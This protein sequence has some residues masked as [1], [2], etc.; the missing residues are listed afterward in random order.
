[1]DEKN[2]E[3]TQKN[4]TFTPIKQLYDENNDIHYLLGQR[5]G[6]GS[7]AKVH[8]IKDEEKDI[9]YAAKIVAK[10]KLKR[11]EVFDGFKNEHEFNYTLE[12]K[13]ICECFSYFE[14]KKYA[15]LIL[16]YCPN[17][18]LFSLLSKR[19]VLK[20]LEIKHYG[21]QLLLAL[22]YLHSRNIIH[23]DLK[24]NNIFLS[25][26][27][28]VRL[29]DFGLAEDTK[30]VYEK[31]NYYICGT[32]KFLAPE[33]LNNEKPEYSEKSDIWAFGVILYTLLCHKTPFEE[34]NDDNDKITI[35]NIIDLNYKF[36]KN[37]CMSSDIKNLIKSILVKNPEKRPTIKEIK[38]SSFFNNGIAIP[39]YLPNYTK[40]R[41]MLTIEEMDYIENALTHGEC[42]DKEC[43]L[44]N[45]DY[46]RNSLMKLYK[47]KKD[48]E[49]EQEL[50]SDI[51]EDENSDQKVLKNIEKNIANTDRKND[52][53]YSININQ[54]MYKDLSKKI[55]DNIIKEKIVEEKRK[56]R[57][58]HVSMEN[59]E[60]KESN[61]RKNKNSSVEKHVE[62][63]EPFLK[64]VNRRRS[65]NMNK[66]RETAKFCMINN[67][68]SGSGSNENNENNENSINNQNNNVEKYKKVKTLKVN[69]KNSLDFDIED[70]EN[71]NHDKNKKLNRVKTVKENNSKLEKD[72]F[73]KNKHIVIEKFIDLSEK[74]GMGYLLSN[75]DN[76]IFFNDYTK[77]VK[78][79]S[80]LNYIYFDDRDNVLKVIKAKKNKIKELEKDTKQKLDIAL[81]VNKSFIRGSKY[82]KN[83]DINKH[84]H[85][86]TVDVYVKEWW[87]EENDYYFLLSNNITQIIFEDKTEV[88]FYISDKIVCYINQLKQK[89]KED[90]NLKRFSSEEMTDK[91]SK[92]RK[93]IL[94]LY[95]L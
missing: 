18:T 14:D 8:I 22:E 6:Y 59:C 65:S 1:M 57:R 26:N 54:F 35:K 40:K 21:F 88:I 87:K 4:N 7:F 67:E 36:P 13:Y 51:S 91:V 47:N 16:E 84:C 92:A 33:I 10:E 41:E 28:E 27:M 45:H 68:N 9:L 43:G 73:E 31:N 69:E 5:L 83:F 55:N 3:I 79:K 75:L 85:K 63:S 66:L 74:C 50:Y 62:I 94:K 32:I 95:K 90:M 2:K 48:K 77:M 46:L 12:F 71:N 61:L 34:K 30:K 37:I 70:N 25:E 82:P 58:K 42:L 20:E 80:T 49:L 29:G 15:Y 19:Y 76:G 39:K 53:R 56:E 81:L 64:K 52:K 38:S 89:F 86:K 17:G 72:V 93:T 78:I 11:D 44:V 60:K 24:L 23:R